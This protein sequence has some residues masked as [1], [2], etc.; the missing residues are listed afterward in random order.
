MRVVHGE[1]G[2]DDGH[3]ESDGQHAGQRAQ[4]ADEH[5]DVGAWHH[6][7]VADCGHG[8]QRPPQTERNAVEVV[9][10]IGLNALRV[11]DEAGEYHDAEGEEKDEQHE[12]LGGGAKRLYEDLEA[13]GVARE[14]EQTH[15][16]D[17]R[18]ELE[19]VG[20]VHVLG[21]R[22]QRQ[23]DVEAEGGDVVDDVDGGADEL[24]FA[25][26]GDEAHQ[27]LER[28]PGVADALDV[29]EG[30]VRVRGKLV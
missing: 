10:R 24:V 28:E 17:D 18:E 11:V 6:V 26:R 5:A 20:V 19:D 3:R 30:R 15:D 8:D 21:E 13:V 23:V 12:L 14:L 9:V 16:A 2:D 27:D 22:L 4:G 29:E 7:A 1:I 25:G